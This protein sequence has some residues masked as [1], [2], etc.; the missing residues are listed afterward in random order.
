MTLAIVSIFGDFLLTK[1][2]I[3]EHCRHDNHNVH[4]LEK[5]FVINVHKSN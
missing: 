5:L 2:N 4:A 1:L 3:V